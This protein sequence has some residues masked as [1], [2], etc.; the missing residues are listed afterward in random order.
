M[1]AGFAVAMTAIGALSLAAASILGPLALMRMS[2]SMLGLKVPGAFGLI[3]NAL[4]I[5]GKGVLWL[6]RLMLAN[7]I[8]A[9]VGLIA[10]AALY[11]WQNWETLGPKFAALWVTIR[12]G[13]IG[14]WNTITTDK[15]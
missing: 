2:F 1:A 3:R 14:A 8:L 10:M 4:G 15:H 13:A 7:P 6:G 11:I 12:D 9:V 5:V